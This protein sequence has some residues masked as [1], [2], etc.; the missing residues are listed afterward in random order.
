[1]RVALSTQFD[2]LFRRYG[3]SIPVAYLRALAYRESGLNPRANAGQNAAQGL[4][5][6]VG[7]ARDSYNQRHGTHYTRDD[8]L[9]PEVNVQIGADLLQRIIA[10]YRK[11]PAQ[12]L[13]EDWSNPAFVQLLTAGWNAGYSDGG[14]VGKV[15]RYLEQRAIPVTPATVYQHAGAAG[16]V[17]TLSSSARAGWHK[18]VA[19]LYL[20]QPDRP[21]GSTLITGALLLLTAWGLHRLLT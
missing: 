3:G 15:A 20:L 8:T 21:Q 1:V 11:H 18:S 16:A 9:D 14:G 10:G 12:N 13:H 2:P 4:L 6:I 7:V 5:Q 17:S 19:D